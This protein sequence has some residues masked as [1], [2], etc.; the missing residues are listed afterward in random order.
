MNTYD[1][2][3]EMWLIKRLTCMPSLWMLFT[4]IIKYIYICYICKLPIEN[5]FEEKGLE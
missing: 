3:R 1:M 2:L 5:V 4:Y